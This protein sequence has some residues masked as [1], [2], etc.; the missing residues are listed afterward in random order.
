MTMHVN[1]DKK[2]WVIAYNE[3]GTVMHLCPV[4]EGLFLS[5]GQPLV[6]VSDNPFDYINS[7][8]GLTDPDYT[9]WDD[10]IGVK[11]ESD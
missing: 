7:V 3:D 4:D 8:A 10:L 2:K 1:A 5:T 6:D 9:L 11:A